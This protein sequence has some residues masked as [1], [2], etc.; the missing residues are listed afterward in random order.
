MP[1]SK[2]QKA[3]ATE[4]LDLIKKSKGGL[5]VY[6]AVGKGGDGSAVHVD[7][8]KPKFCVAT[9]KAQRVTTILASGQLKME[10]Q[11]T[12]YCLRD[13]NENAVRKAFFAFFKEA[14]VSIPGVTESKI[15]VLGPKEWD[16]AS[17][18]EEAGG[19]STQ[20]A[21]PP[22]SG[23]DG[24]AGPELPPTVSATGAAAAP[25][26]ASSPAKQA[27]NDLVAAYQKLVPEMKRK[28]AEQPPLQEPLTRTAKQFQE[29]LN[30]GRLEDAKSALERLVQILA[31]PVEDPAQEFAK[32]YAALKPR[33]EQ[34]VRE[35]RGDTSKM[36]AG[37]QFAV[38]AA[39]QKEFARALK[40]LEQ[41]ERL[42]ESATGSD[43][44]SGRAGT[45][46]PAPGIDYKIS[47]LNWESAQKKVRSE[48]QKLEAA[49]LKD[50]AQEPKFPVIKDSLKKL[51][52]VLG[53]F[54]ERLRDKLDEAMSA[55]P[56][57][58]PNLHK[59]ALEILDEYMDYVDTD[60]LIDAI[61]SNPFVPVS[62]REPLEKTLNDIATQ[63]RS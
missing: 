31:G 22:P 20:T 27:A 53:G 18:D 46:K 28:A 3:N 42:V 45:G 9:L 43:L 30:G 21:Q 52:E 60:G 55:P 25:A 15:R 51:E 61:D 44:A 6:F 2:E 47:L 37:A 11:L 12:L 4:F 29:A 23:T 40:A 19:T 26:P 63:L 59:E 39:N 54:D 13:A 57:E 48:L 8:K 34:A 5:K 14:G 7:K 62:V 35:G 49:I 41:L 50:F 33:L 1:A 58:L 24:A 16:S 32:R 56:A 17:E 38:D 36:R 10:D